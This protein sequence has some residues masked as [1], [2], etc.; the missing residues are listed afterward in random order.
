MVQSNGGNGAVMM[1]STEGETGRH[2][3]SP[4]EQDMEHGREDA[5]SRQDARRDSAVERAA[6]SHG[7]NEDVKRAAAGEGREIQYS[8]LVQ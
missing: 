6:D 4:T 8:T 3:L 2:S 1:P 7:S 5:I